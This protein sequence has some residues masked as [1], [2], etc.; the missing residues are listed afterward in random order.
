MFVQLQWVAP[1]HPFYVGPCW[2]RVGVGKVLL[3]RSV[4][5]ITITTFAIYKPVPSFQQNSITWGGSK[6]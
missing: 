2:M 4:I 1:K 5:T 3:T 6:G